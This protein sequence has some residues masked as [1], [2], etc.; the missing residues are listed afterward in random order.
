ML[1]TAWEFTYQR[2]PAEHLFE[3]EVS[4]A[5]I[6]AQRLA[7]TGQQIIGSRMRR[8]GRLPE[9]WRLLQEVAEAIAAVHAGFDMGVSKQTVPR[10]RDDLPRHQFADRGWCRR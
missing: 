3:T 1:R 7:S 5:G 2:R 8:L 4:I 9:R 6:T 10:L